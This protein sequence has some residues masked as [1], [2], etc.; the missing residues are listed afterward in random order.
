MP[1][2][3]LRRRRRRP[4]CR[5][6]SAPRFT[7]GSPTCLSL[8]LSLSLCLACEGTFYNRASGTILFCHHSIYSIYPLSHISLSSPT[9]SQ[10]HPALRCLFGRANQRPPKKYDCCWRHRL[11]SLHP[12]HEKRGLIISS[13]RRRRG[14]LMELRCATLHFSQDFLF[15]N[16]KNQSPNKYDPISP[17]GIASTLNTPSVW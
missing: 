7:V 9:H 10:S 1:L 15:R 4:R 6:P 16:L 3:A 12:R 8:S 14:R 5:A 17:T 11:P 13:D 2:I